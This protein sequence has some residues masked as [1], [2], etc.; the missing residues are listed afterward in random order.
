MTLLLGPPGSGK[1]SLL[2]AV[3]GK[4]RVH[5]HLGQLTVRE[6][7]EFFARCQGTGHHPQILA[8]LARREQELGINP[9]NADTNNIF[10]N[11]T[12]EESPEYERLTTNYI[13]K[14]LSLRRMRRHTGGRR[15]EA[16]NLRRPE[17]ASQYRSVSSPPLLLL[18]VA[19]DNARQCN[20]AMSLS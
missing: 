11:F 10:L 1:T 15:D 12:T 4:L 13:L 8:D 3:A 16:R 6:T 7:L 19:Q 20:I 17:K 5:V 14:T 18:K 2:L 9:G